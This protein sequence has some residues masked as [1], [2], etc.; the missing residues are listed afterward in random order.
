LYVDDDDGYKNEKEN[1]LSEMRFSFP[2]FRCVRIRSAAAAE[3][4]I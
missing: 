1:G 2:D 4:L 3:K